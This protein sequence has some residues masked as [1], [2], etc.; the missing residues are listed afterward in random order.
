MDISGNM[1]VR[2]RLMTA[3]D[4][5]QAMQLKDAAGWN[6]TCADWLRFLSANPEG[7]FVADIEGRILGTSASIV[8]EGKLSMDRHGDS[9]CAISRTGN[10]HNPSSICYSISRFATDSVYK[11]RR[12]AP[13]ECGTQRKLRKFLRDQHSF[14]RSNSA[15]DEY[16]KRILYDYLLTINL[17]VM[18]CIC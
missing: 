16:R 18:H 17:C 13:W 14:A 2:F 9:G 7:C 15:F 12:H 4:I 5:P 8:Y 11:A 6:Q 10:R 3:A 1:G